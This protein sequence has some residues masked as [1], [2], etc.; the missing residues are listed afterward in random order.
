MMMH[1]HGMM[2]SSMTGQQQPEAEE[3]EERTTT[4]T[5]NSKG[6]EQSE[7]DSQSLRSETESQNKG[8]STTLYVL[9]G[10]GMLLMMGLVML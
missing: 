7:N 2:G 6:S 8:P 10:I 9:G 1:D 4:S 3:I 5:E